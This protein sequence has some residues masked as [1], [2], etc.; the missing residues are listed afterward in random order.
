MKNLKIAALIFGLLFGAVVNAAAQENTFNEETLSKLQTEAEQEIKNKSFR[1]KTVEERSD[2]SGLTED[3]TTLSVLEVVPP[4]RE[5]LISKTETADGVKIYETINVG[6]RS[7]IREDNGV[8]RE[9][10]GTGSGRGSGSGSG[11]GSGEMKVETTTVRNLKKGE[12]V[13]NQ[14]G[15]LYETTTTTKNIYPN[16]TYTH[17][18]K[19]SY[20]FDSKGLLIKSINEY[21]DL[22][23]KRL[24]RTTR[25]YEYDPK[26]KIEIPVIAP[27]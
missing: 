6:G 14:I 9:T 22:D 27:K 17:V 16:K 26:I 25:D 20:W 24:S 21:E 18:S 7:F 3:R 19:S 10:T 5:H 2:K 11:N 15:D 23:D 13:N 4:D 1:V 8:W 12:K